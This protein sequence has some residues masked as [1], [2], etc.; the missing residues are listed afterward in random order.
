[1]IALKNVSKSYGQHL[2][3]DKVSLT[4]Q[5]DEFISIHGESGS[6]K[7]TLLRLLLRIEDPTAGSIEVDGANILSLPQPILQLYRSRMGVMFQDPPLLSHLTVAEN[8]ALPLELLNAP[9]PLIRRNTADLIKRLGLMQVADTLPAFLSKSERSLA[10]IARALITAPVILLADEPLEHLDDAQQET[11]KDILTTMHKQ[12]TTVILFTRSSELARVMPGRH[13]ELKDGKIVAR[14]AQG[15]AASKDSHR[16][17]E[18]E[19]A[20]KKE[21]AEEVPVTEEKPPKSGG[22]KIRITSIGSNL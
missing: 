19:Q 13:A 10:G 1:M 14:A 8:I 15:K 22:K 2:I 16:I 20:P 21:E 7:T 5:P 9:S 17:L 6:G 12:G 11:V 3:L 4:I 18:E